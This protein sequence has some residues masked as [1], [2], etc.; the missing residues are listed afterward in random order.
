MYMQLPSGNDFLFGQGNL[1]VCYFVVIHLSLVSHNRIM[2]RS[3]HVPNDSYIDGLVQERR[4]SIALAMELPYIFLALTHR[5]VMQIPPF[6][7]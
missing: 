5:C 7:F 6:L 3:S 2:K 4:N 1:S